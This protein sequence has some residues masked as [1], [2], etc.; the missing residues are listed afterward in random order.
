MHGR[1]ADFSSRGEFGS[2]LFR[3]T[4]VAPGVDEVSLRPSTVA[5]VTTAGGLADKR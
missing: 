1:L 2:P 4:L 3:P 5:S